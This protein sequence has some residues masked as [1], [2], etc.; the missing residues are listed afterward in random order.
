[1]IKFR[2]WLADKIERASY[3]LVDRL[4]FTR[5]SRRYKKSKTY[6]GFITN[7]FDSRPPRYFEGGFEWQRGPSH[8]DIPMKDTLFN[9]FEDRH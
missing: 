2:W 9:P 8:S 5:K 6:P 7:R 1:M 4:R 3:N